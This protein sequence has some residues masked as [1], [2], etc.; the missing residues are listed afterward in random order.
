MNRVPNDAD[1][2]RQDSQSLQLP[3]VAPSMVS[4]TAPIDQVRRDIQQ[5]ATVIGP[6]LEEILRSHWEH[7]GLN[8]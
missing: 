8:E 1:A 7:W 6:V 2:V 3:L 4:R 5:R